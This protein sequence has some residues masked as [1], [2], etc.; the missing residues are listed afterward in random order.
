MA[1]RIGIEVICIAWIHQ[2]ESLPTADLDIDIVK[3]VI[4]TW[5]MAS[6]PSNAS[7]AYQ[8]KQQ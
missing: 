6:V 3:Q 4:V 8:K 7:K 1:L 2:K 5:I